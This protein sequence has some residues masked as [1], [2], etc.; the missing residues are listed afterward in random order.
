MN[1]VDLHCHST[2]SDGRLA[3]AEVVRLA[4]ES[5]L[6]GL[7]LTDHDTVAGIAE[8]SDEA[9]RVGI[10]FI[11]GIEISAK[12]PAPGTLHILGYGVNPDSA[13]L[14]SLTD[15]LIADRDTRNP[16]IIQRL[17]AMN[18]HVSM[19]EWQAEAGDGV[20]GRPHLAAILVRKGYASSVKNAFEKFIGHGAPAYVEKDRLSPRSALQAIRDSAGLAVLAHPS[21]LRVGNDAELERVVKDLVDLGL[22]GIEV[23]HSDHDERWIERC[24]QLARRFGLLRSGGSDFHGSN[25][26][27]ISLGMAAGRRIPREYF[28]QLR[29]RLSEVKR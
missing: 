20:V 16:R 3:P 7:S 14:R 15:R 22:V 4:S 24:E 28:D 23:L 21:Q 8:A 1:F 26:P 25:K 2:A 6:T 17:N 9:E 13:A 27:G 11:S 29:E 12:F 10:D 19:D 18:V 5:G